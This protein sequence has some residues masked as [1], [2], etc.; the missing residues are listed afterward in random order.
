VYQSGYIIV[1]NY[2]ASKERATPCQAVAARL[3][4]NQ[5]YSH[6]LS[7]VVVGNVIPSAVNQVHVNHFAAHASLYLTINFCQSVGVQVRVKVVALATADNS[8]TSVTSTS[9][10]AVASSVVVTT[11]CVI[12]LLVSVLVEEIVGIAT[13][14]NVT[15]QAEPLASVV[16]V[17][18]HSSIEVHIVSVVQMFQALAADIPQEVLIAH[19]VEDVVS[20][21]L[22]ANIEALA[23]VHHIVRSVVAQARAVNEAEAVVILVVNAGDVP[24]TN[25]Q[26]QVSSDITQA[27]SAE[28][29]AAITDNL[30][31]VYTQ[32]VTVAAFQDIFV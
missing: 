12:A 32:F 8:Y 28:D 19:V 6:L 16:S 23:H 20:S 9:I 18:C 2:Y 17:A 21:V 29:V 1:Y 7:V 15:T 13:H 14:C 26:D 3:Y 25:N 27:S 24:N 11:L 5:T 4:V 10:T 31:V 22:G 30:L